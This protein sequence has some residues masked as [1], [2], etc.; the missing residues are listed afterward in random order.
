MGR[1]K[2]A[3]TNFEYLKAKQVLGDRAKYK[4]IILKLI[5]KILCMA[6]WTEFVLLWTFS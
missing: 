4:G 6:V 1:I 2:N 5:L 3:P